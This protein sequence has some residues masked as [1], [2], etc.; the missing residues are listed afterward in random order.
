MGR[1]LSLIVVL[2]LLALSATGCGDQGADTPTPEPD[3]DRDST[4]SVTGEVTPAEQATLTIQ[5]GGKVVSV[6][7]EPGSQAAEGELLVQLDS[8]DEELA[9]Q[10]AQAALKSARA[11]LALVETAARPQEIEVAEAQVRAA[12]AALSQAIAERNRLLDGAAEVEAVAAEAEVARAEAAY[13]TALIH[14]DGV[15][16]EEEEVE[17]W[18]EEEAALQ[19]RAAEQALEAAR[20]QLRQTQAGAGA[21]ARAA[22]AA[23][24]EAAA[25]RNIA[26]ARLDMLQ[27]G[28]TA[29]EI[30]VARAGVSQ[31]QV[32]LDA[33][34]ASL[35]RCELRAPFDGT[36]GSVDVRARELVTP[37]QPLIAIGKL[38]TLRVETTDLNEVDVARVAVGQKASITFD[39]FPEQAFSGR[40]VRISP[41]ADPGGGGV[42]Y[43]AIIEIEELSPKIMW[44]MTAFVDIEVE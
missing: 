25:Q 35:E 3:P 41:M 29:E 44:G 7:V 34:R 10:Q 22:D 26:Q 27:A 14:Y 20:I 24:R 12:Q 9:V 16:A 11:Q 42:N 40:V 36:I 19:L 28:A 31:A 39:A 37:G 1:K 13:R 23:V 33:A 2:G 18:V 17:D 32:E 21:Q 8:T 6:S 38:D 4:I 30:A 5:S 15:R 43:T